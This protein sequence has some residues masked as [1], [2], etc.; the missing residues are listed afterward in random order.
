MRK[1]IL[2]DFAGPSRHQCFPRPEAVWI[3][4]IL[5][6]RCPCFHIGSVFCFSPQLM[7]VLGLR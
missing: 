3:L 6:C 4:A 7:L 1:K 5:F 2:R